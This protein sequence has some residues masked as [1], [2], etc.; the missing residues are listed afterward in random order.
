MSNGKD[1]P[2]EHDSW[3]PTGQRFTK[4]K[5][6]PVFRTNTFTY[7]CTDRLEDDERDIEE[8][9]RVIER[10]GRNSN[11]SRESICFRVSDVSYN[12]TAMNPRNPPLSSPLNR[13][14]RLKNGRMKISTLRLTRRF[15]A[16]SSGVTGKY[17]SGLLASCV[18]DMPVVGLF[19]S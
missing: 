4:K 18:P 13:Y 10:F 11:I 14:M 2:T 15:I 7:S 6:S 8:T 16:F 17:P 9:D 1:T 12:Q 19:S 5:I 3:H